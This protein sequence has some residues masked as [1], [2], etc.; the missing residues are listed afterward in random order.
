MR[1]CGRVLGI[2][3]VA[4]LLTGGCAKRALRAAADQQQ[5]PPPASSTAEATGSRTDDD[6]FDGVALDAAARQAL[7]P[8]Y[9]AFNRWDL[10]PDAMHA[11][12]GVVRFL[13]ERPGA[14]VLA[15]GHCDE[16]GSSEYNIGLGERRAA[17][18]G[19]WLTA[20]GI[21][22][23]R[24]E[25]TSYGKERPAVVGCGDEECHARNRRVEWVLLAAQGKQVSLA[26]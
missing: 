12:E 7:A 17:A 4:V 18:V 3:F 19:Q 26:P 10:Q 23:G 14:R 1:V 21:A 9:F 5:A 20:Y 25:T 13:N 24:T 11:L 2:V 6:A 22:A 16:R 15:E 8:I